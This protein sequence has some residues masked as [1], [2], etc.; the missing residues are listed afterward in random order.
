MSKQ[1]TKKGLQNGNEKDKHSWNGYINCRLD[2]N[3]LVD[4]AEGSFTQSD[5]MKRLLDWTRVGYKIAITPNDA[6]TSITASMTDR[7]IGST[8][9]GYTLSAF[10]PDVVQ[11][12][13]ALAYKHEVLMPDGWVIGEVSRPNIG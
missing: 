11:A 4:M 6:G 9:H 13:K 8:S 1:R 5:V 7:D 3:H 10:A 12:M 2:S